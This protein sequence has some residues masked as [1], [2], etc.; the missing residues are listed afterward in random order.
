VVAGLDNAGKTSLLLA[1]EK[2]FDY[3]DE[4]KNLTPTQGIQRTQFKFLKRNIYRWDFGGQEKY[5]QEYLA[6][7]ERNLTEISILFYVIDVQ[8]QARFPEVMEYLRHIV[9]FVREKKIEVPIIIILNKYDPKL[10]DNEKIIHQVMNLKELVTEIVQPK[11]PTF[12]ITSIYDIDSIMQAFSQSLSQMFPRLEMIQDI[13]Q[14][15]T[16]THP[17]L[18]ML[19]MDE[20]GITIADY[21]QSHLLPKERDAIRLLRIQALKKIVEKGVGGLRFEDDAYPGKTIFGEIRSFPVEGPYFYLLFISEDKTLI[22]QQIE[23]TVPR[24]EKILWNVLK[25]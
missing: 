15:F 4:V 23:T 17:V 22:S 16:K 19:L 8:D 6:Q 20:N 24:V 21:Y 9:N 7:M 10:K 3:E 1:L 13:F 18:A 2:K 12:F 5:R 25:V 11:T 14:D